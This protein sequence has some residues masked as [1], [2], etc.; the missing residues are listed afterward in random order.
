MKMTIRSGL[1]VLA[2]T[3][4]AQAQDAGTDAAQG[5]IRQ[6][7]DAFLADDFDR[8]FT[9]ASPMI[10]RMFGNSGNFGLMVKNG[11][12]MVWR[13]AD[14]RFGETEMRGDTVLQRV[15]ITDQAG[16]THVLMYEMMPDGDSYKINGV[17]ILRAPQVGA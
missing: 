6:Q 16:G 11:Y 15:V 13:P 14:V 3:L 9:F 4:G 12:P 10:Q 5:V 17:H 1:L 7:I 2:M 8:A